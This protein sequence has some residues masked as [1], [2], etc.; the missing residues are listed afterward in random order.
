MKK[1]LLLECSEAAVMT[2]EALPLNLSFS[3]FSHHSRA[4]KKE[5]ENDLKREGKMH[6]TVSVLLYLIPSPAQ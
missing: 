1:T 2:L 5:K 6:Q 3:L 4:V